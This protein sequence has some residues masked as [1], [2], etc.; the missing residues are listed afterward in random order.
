MWE[1][2]NDAFGLRSTSGICDEGV[3]VPY[4]C[5]AWKG[6]NEKVLECSVSV[7]ERNS[8]CGKLRL[9]QGHDPPREGNLRLAEVECG[10]R[11]DNGGIQSSSSTNPY[12]DDG[13]LLSG[14]RQ[15]AKMQ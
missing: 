9:R 8:I 5:I 3:S 11:P 4:T 6:A 15:L 13:R 12:R 10:G 2:T 7:G 1:I 14:A